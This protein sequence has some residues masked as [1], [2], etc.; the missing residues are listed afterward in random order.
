MLAHEVARG[1][2]RAVRAQRVDQ[3]AAARAAQRLARR[4]ALHERDRG[5]LLQRQRQLRL[6]RRRVRKI[7]DPLGGGEHLEFAPARRVLGLRT[8]GSVQHEAALQHRHAARPLEARVEARVDVVV[9]RHL[10]PAG[11]HLHLRR[12]EVLLRPLPRASEEAPTVTVEE[13]QEEPVAE[14]RGGRLARADERE[15]RLG[16][17]GADHLLQAEHVGHARRR[18][19]RALGGRHHRHLAVQPLPYLCVEELRGA[20]GRLGWRGHLAGDAD[21]DD[22]WRRA[23]RR[24]VPWAGDWR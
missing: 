7:G 2:Q 22:A 6:L 11:Q 3:L 20:L 10:A 9:D 13:R 21:G 16:K 19:L 5:A 24:G 1:L 15:K 17:L 14:P 12:R 23:E 18:P 8:I 4:L